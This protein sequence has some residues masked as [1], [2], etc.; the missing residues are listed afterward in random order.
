MRVCVYVFVCMYEPVLPTKSAFQICSWW[1]RTLCMNSCLPGA[2]ALILCA[3]P[4]SS[5][6][7]VSRGTSW[8]TTLNP[9]GLDYRFI[10]SA[11][12]TVARLLILNCGQ[13]MIPIA[14]MCN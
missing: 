4:C 12:L 5:W 10:E 8:R 7:R 3:P 14:C 9:M 1:A 2:G 13:P 6:C 11:N